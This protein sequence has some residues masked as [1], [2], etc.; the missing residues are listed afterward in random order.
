MNRWAILNRPT[1]AAIVY[2]CKQWPQRRQACA[3]IHQ[4]V[5]PSIASLTRSSGPN[6][7]VASPQV[8]LKLAPKGVGVALG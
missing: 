1:G 4:Q 5:R 8:R 3:G 2:A 7:I 6:L